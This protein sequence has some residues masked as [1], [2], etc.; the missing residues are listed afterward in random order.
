MSTYFK[1]WNS[2]ITAKDPDS[3]VPEPAPVA[4]RLSYGKP[5]SQ[6]RE[7]GTA[8]WTVMTLAAFIDLWDR[9]NTNKNSSGTVVIPGRTSGQSWT[10]WQR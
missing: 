8:S 9:Y 3:Y 10:T 5:I 7:A 6:G 1:V 2:L 4:G